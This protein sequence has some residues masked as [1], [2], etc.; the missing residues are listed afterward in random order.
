M[1]AR[2]AALLEAIVAMTILASTGVAMTVL[3]A[4]SV[5][6][7]ANASDRGANLID[8]DRFLRAVTLW[9]R[10]DLDRHLGD[11]E[12]GAWWMR[13]DRRGDLYRIGLRHERDGPEFIS[14]MLYRP[15]A[16]AAEDPP[17]EASATG[18]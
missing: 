3:G 11:R 5:R 16:V 10:D 7:V 2:G 15:A 13:V 14:T 1:S 6:L 18:P 4:E 12:Q 9:P 8:A 17:A